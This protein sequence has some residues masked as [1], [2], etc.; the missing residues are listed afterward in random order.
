MSAAEKHSSLPGILGEIA[1]AV[2]PEAALQIARQ[3]GGVRKDIPARARKDHWLTEC[4]G[5]EMADR[6]CRHLAI[7]D[8]DGRRKGVVYHEVIP[9]G[10][11]S[12]MKRARRQIA[13]A[14]RSGKS[15]RTAAREA[16]LH[17]R[18]GWR[19]NSRLKDRD[20]DQGS[21]F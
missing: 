15:V 6:I 4:V 3:Y 11:A 5:F 18:T 2:G 20:D 17:E 10:P 12:M 8:A 14:I 13:D 1:D 21:L 9:L 7:Q 16:G 19:I